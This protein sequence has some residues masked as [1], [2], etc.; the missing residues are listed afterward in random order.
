MMEIVQE[1]TSGSKSAINIT[2]I[3]DSLAGIESQE[4]FRRTTAG[5][6]HQT[7][8]IE[9][10]LIWKS[11]ILGDYRTSLL[12]VLILKKFKNVFKNIGDQKMDKLIL[13]KMQI[14]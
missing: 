4:L 3:S 8:Q 10:G 11:T 1:S 12:I 6:D 13:I 14:I 9:I 7:I 2:L 5:S